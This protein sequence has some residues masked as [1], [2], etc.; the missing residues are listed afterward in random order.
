MPPSA[1]AAFG[2]PGARSS[3][4]CGLQLLCCSDKAHPSGSFREVTTDPG[5]TS[6]SVQACCL[7]HLS[8]FHPG[9]RAGTG[10]QTHSRSPAAQ[11]LSSVWIELNSSGQWQPAGCPPSPTRPLLS[12]FPVGLR[13]GLLR[14][15]RPNPLRDSSEQSLGT[16]APPKNAHTPALCRLGGNGLHHCISS[17][18][19]A[20]SAAEDGAR[21]RVCHC[22]SPKPVFFATT[23][24]CSPRTPLLKIR[25]HWIVELRRGTEGR[26]E[27][28]AAE[29]PPA[30]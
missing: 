20:A 3:K 2:V 27:A 9:L 1:R 25:P 23:L 24:T 13:P 11:T 12:P 26:P 28:G 17:S 7:K 6:L 29:A 8:G 22:L 4:H 15:T 14:G 10:G 16:L 18:F 30:R 21:V 5:L 19:P